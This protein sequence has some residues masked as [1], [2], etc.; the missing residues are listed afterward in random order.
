MKARTP[1]TMRVAGAIHR[2]MRERGLTR[3]Y[4]VAEAIGVTPT[5]VG[6]WLSGRYLPSL[7][8]AAEL[9]DHLDGPEILFLVRQASVGTCRVCLAP[10]TR[11]TGNTRTRRE[12]CNIECQRAYHKGVSAKSK[13]PAE[14]A[15]AD[16]CAGCEPEGLCRTPDCPLRAYSPFVYV[17]RRVA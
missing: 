6:Y 7:E 1:E 3:R 15:I 11:I 8:K 12:Y 17:A 16:Y 4:Q 5:M 9:A 13:H 2:R 10:F 14:L